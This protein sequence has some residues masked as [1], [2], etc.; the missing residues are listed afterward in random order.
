MLST[1]RLL[2]LLASLGYF[3]VCDAA[4]TVWNPIVQ[5]SKGQV[6]GVQGADA[7]R[8]MLPYAKAPVGSL[9]FQRPQAVDRFNGSV[10]PIEI[11]QIQANHAFVASSTFDGTRLPPAC[12]QA[13]QRSGQLDAS[14]SEDCL[15]MNVY[16]PPA[17]LPDAELPVL[18]WVHG[19]SFTSGSI[20]A[21][22][23]SKLARSQNMIVVTVQ[24]RLGLFGWLKLNRW[25]IEGN[26]GLRDVIMALEAV[27]KDI[28]GFG[29][30]PTRVTLAGHS[31]GAQMVQ[32][33][34]AAPSAT[35][36]FHRAILHS[37]PL[38]YAPQSPSLA[39][40]VGSI[41]VNQN[42]KARVKSQILPG[43]LKSDNDLI[44]AQS[45]L[46]QKAALGGIADIPQAEPFN[47]VLDGD[48]VTG[49]GRDIVA[50]GKQII[51]TTMKDEACNAVEAG[52]FAAGYL[53][54]AADD[55]SGLVKLSYPKRGD[56]IIDS[57]L[58]QPSSDDEAVIAEDLVDLTTDFVW[59][60]PNQQ[61]ALS[62]A[63]KS[64]VYLG[65][66]D[67]GIQATSNRYSKLCT[68][69]VG[70]EDDIA[71]VFNTPSSELSSAQTALVKEVQT[72]WGEFARSGKPD[73]RGYSAW[74]ALSATEGIKVLELG[75]TTTGG[76]SLATSQRTDTCAFYA[77]L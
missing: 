43:G 71:V 68:T 28:K 38:D 15:Y 46:L 64:T 69:K 5:T 65:K 12:L 42:L 67:L 32:A 70:H 18:V 22:D 30:D 9:R 24:Y 13:D 31:S 52:T 29:G 45:V 25:D 26:Y 36:L 60:C 50:S 20:A 39:A 11:L 76:S 35:S 16:T 33:L 7:R 23:G 73:G 56:A 34:L 17:N 1:K 58:Y 21:L 75:S 62:A 47:V 72:R 59:V 4:A 55:F 57:K 74:P 51:Y 77:S 61:T 3:V 66:F 63:S 49:N 41:L 10:F 14:T 2:A 48:L 27:Q 54:I 44:I 6:V 19:G 53:D 37:A 8:Y 40:S